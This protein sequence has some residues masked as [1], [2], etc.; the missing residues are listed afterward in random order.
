MAE[1]LICIGFA[2]LAAGGAL[3]VY[4]SRRQVHEREV[5]EVAEAVARQHREARACG[6]YGC[7]VAAYRV[8]SAAPQ[9][10]ATT[11]SAMPA[12]GSIPLFPASSPATCHLLGRVGHQELGRQRARRAGASGRQERRHHHG[13][14]WARCGS[15]LSL[16][17]P[18]NK[19]GVTIIEVGMARPKSGNASTPAEK[20]RR[21]RARLAAKAAAKAAKAAET[22]A[23]ASLDFSRMAPGHLAQLIWDRRGR[24]SRWRCEPRSPSGPRPKM[25]ARG[26]C[27]MA[28]SPETWGRAAAAFTGP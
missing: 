3:M 25:P 26:W 2:C 9:C 18:G 24:G 10:S 28:S 13:R 16:A 11:G 15:P 23:A 5:A 17:S 12:C 22:Q 8:G 4:G 14:P 19:V 7:R 27:W 21:Y 6:R 1:G 20:Q